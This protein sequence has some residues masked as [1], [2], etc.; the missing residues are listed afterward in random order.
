L[1][2][3]SAVTGCEESWRN[4]SRACEVERVL[5]VPNIPSSRY[6][7]PV[8]DSTVIDEAARRLVAAAPGARVLL[9]GSH[10]GATRDLIAI[11]IS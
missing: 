11:S 8:F 1:G 5:W 3:A 10:P 2:G 4:E 6:G 7:L 9:F